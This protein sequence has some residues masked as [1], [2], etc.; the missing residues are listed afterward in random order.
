MARTVLQVFRLSASP[1]ESLL[2]LKMRDGA[3]TCGGGEP[4]HTSAILLVFSG[5]IFD[6][7]RIAVPALVDYTSCK[8]SREGT[9]GQAP[10]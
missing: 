5:I 7:K 2:T 8:E 6:R 3:V 1:E 9:I 4:C 10:R